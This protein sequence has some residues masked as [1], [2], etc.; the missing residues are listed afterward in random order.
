M[1][2]VTPVLTHP[3]PESS[4]P[5]VWTG[6]SE[7]LKVEGVLY[8][9]MYAWKSVYAGLGGPVRPGRRHLRF[10][11]VGPVHGDP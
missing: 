6:G 9:K 7:E 10:T 3:N 5:S 11:H 2:P 1:S 8:L 4:E